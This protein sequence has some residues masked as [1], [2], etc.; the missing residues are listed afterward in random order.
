MENDADHIPGENTYLV[1]VDESDECRVATR[2]A[3]LRARNSG[4]R[5]I[6]LYVIEPSDFQHWT[7]VSDVMAREGRQEAEE[8]LQ[9]LAA[10]IHEYAD[11][12]PVLFVQDGPKIEQILK[13]IDEQP[14]I[15][16][17]VLGCAPEGKGTNNLVQE[18]TKELT[19]RLRIPLL[20]VPGN[21]TE[22][23]IKSLT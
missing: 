22:D 7:A 19:K 12:R 11:I 16:A 17:M 5:V 1:C 8:R 20:I 9:L 15:N 4:G 13:L 3:A 21:L 6:L 14:D 18:L 10:E 2:L 23:Q